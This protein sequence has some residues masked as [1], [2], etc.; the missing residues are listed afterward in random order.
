MTI[1]SALLLMIVGIIA[2]VKGGDLFVASS[3][4]LARHLRISPVLIGTTL[5]SLA[6]TTPELAVSVTASLRGNPGLALGNAVGSAI[7]NVGL[8][9]GVLCILH[10][11]TVRREDFT[12]PARVMLGMGAL[13]T[14]LTFRLGLGRPAGLLLVLCIAGYLAV[15]YVRHRKGRA[16]TTGPPDDATDPLW[17][18]GR[19]LILFV[20][21]AVLVLMGSRLMADNAVRLAT[22]IGVP[23]IIIGLTVVAVGTSLPE[24]VTAITAAKKGVPELSLGNLVGANILNI[25]LI[26]GVSALVH[27]L[28]MTRATQ[29][30]NFPAM[31]ILFLL[32]LLLA[33]T[34]RKLT[35]AEGW[36]LI[37]A[38]AC[39]LGGLL[40]FGR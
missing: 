9:V 22:M 11:L 19:A 27:P 3:V 6:T 13:L 21:G 32:L 5:V 7:C 33:R 8:V 36:I 18:R 23:P 31:L 39:F 38:Y 28:T 29:R 20:V 15:D 40:V 4:A 30:Y 1:G 17:S 14:V 16:G 12:L 25:T 35:R 26:P 10:P 37:A 34:G 24:L 2:I